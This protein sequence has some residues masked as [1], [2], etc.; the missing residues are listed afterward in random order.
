MQIWQPAVI[1]TMP[2]MVVGIIVGVLGVGI[3]I[4]WAFSFLSLRKLKNY[5]D[6][7]HDLEEEG[8]KGTDG[9]QEKKVSQL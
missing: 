5:L 1:N 6:N 4:W 2:F 7:Y 3:L 8:D 9:E